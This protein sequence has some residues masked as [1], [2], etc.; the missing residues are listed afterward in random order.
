MNTTLLITG[1]SQGLGRAL[2]LHCA[3]LGFKLALVARHEA[4]LEALAQT[5]R[6]SGGEAI[7]LAYDVADKHAIYPLVG[8]AT[9]ALG[10]I[11]VLVNNASTLGPVPLRPLAETEC[12]D[13]GRVFQTNLVG[14]FRLTKAVIGGMVLRQR[15]L[16]V[17]VSSDAAVSAYPTWGA[18]GA[19]KAACDHLG[20]IWAAELEGSGVQI[21]SFDPG[22]MDTAMH[23]AA[24]P[25]AKREALAR[26]EDIAQRLAQDI[27]KRVT[28]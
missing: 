13:L 19:S 21:F 18:Y 16:V 11:D 4:P 1:A 15:G 8:R 23:A 5:I 3:S 17:N 9:A 12:E 7:A 24:M 20:R 27:L 2:A 26:P 28:P 10:S 6:A 25:E 22:E 14:P